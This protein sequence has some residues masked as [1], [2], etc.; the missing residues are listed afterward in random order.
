MKEAMAA[1]SEPFCSLMLTI[2]SNDYPPMK[3]EE[4]YYSEIK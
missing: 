3:R 2:A 1:L 4:Q